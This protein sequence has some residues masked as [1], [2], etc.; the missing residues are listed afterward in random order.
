MA[1]PVCGGFIHPVAGRCKHCKTDLVKLRQGFAPHAGAGP[2]AGYAPPAYP[3]EGHSVAAVPWPPAELPAPAVA[4]TQGSPTPTAPVVYMPRSGGVSRPSTW[5][6]TWPWLAVII[7]II[8]IA[9]SMLLLFLD[10]RGRRADARPLKKRVAAPER[11]DTAPLPA[12]VPPSDPWK[13]MPSGPDQAPSDPGS[14][15]APDPRTAPPRAAAPDDPLPDPG[16]GTGGALGVAP[17]AGEFFASLFKIACSRLASC[18][19]MGPPIQTMCEELGSI[20]PDADLT[21]NI[22]SGQCRYDRDRAARCLRTVAQ[23]PC[24]SQTI[25]FGQLAKQFTSIQ[26]CATAIQCN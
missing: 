11:M 18:G 26:D 4:I 9:G 5:S 16:T 19:A 17:D 8:A 13:G 22:N 1:C 12:P 14:D 15:P 2:A 21:A 25:D 6:R 10:D 24:Q 23:L 3:P 7:A 20:Q